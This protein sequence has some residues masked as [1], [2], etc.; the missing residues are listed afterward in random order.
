LHALVFSERVILGD[1][2]N[3]WLAEKRMAIGCR[4]RD[5]RTEKSYL[6]RIYGGSRKSNTRDYWAIMDFAQENMPTEECRSMDY[7][8]LVITEILLHWNQLAPDDLDNIEPDCSQL[9][10]LLESRYG[11]CRNRAERE[12]DAFLADLAGRLQRAAGA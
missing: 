9:A 4:I 7:R 2:D 10:A 6:V 12:A 11:F 3:K 5:P 1:G 8:N